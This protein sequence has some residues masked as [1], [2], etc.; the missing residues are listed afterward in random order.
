[1]LQRGSTAFRYSAFLLAAVVLVCRM[2]LLSGL[3][4]AAFAAE[5]WLAPRH[6]NSATPTQD[7]S[8]V[9]KCLLQLEPA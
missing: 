2:L 7:T 3:A 1:M 8:G 9:Q 5:T 6:V 4:L